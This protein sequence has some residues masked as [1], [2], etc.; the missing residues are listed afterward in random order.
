M[1]ISFQMVIARGALLLLLTMC[2]HNSAPSQDA[3]HG[4][5]GVVLKETPVNRS[6]RGMPV[7]FLPGTTQAGNDVGSDNR[8]QPTNSVTPPLFPD[9]SGFTRFPGLEGGTVR[10]ITRDSSGW[11]Y[12]GTDGE[13]YVSSDNGTHWKMNLFPSQVHNFVEPVTILGPTTI[14]AESDFYN[15]ISRDRGTTWEYISGN[16]Q[17]FAVD[18]NGVVY[19]GSDYGGV[20]RS[21]DTAKTW[22]PFGL[23]GKKV[24][25]V[26]LC[27]AGRIA[28]PSDSGSYFST[29]SGTTWR[30]RRND[31]L[32]TSA[33]I[34]DKRGRLFVFSYRD[35]GLYRSLDFGIT[36]QRLTLPSSVDVYR[37][38]VQSD[39]EVLAVG[40]GKVLSSLDGGDTWSQLDF[41][42]ESPLT[43]GRDALGNLLVGSFMGVHKWNGGSGEWEALNT[44]LYGRR[45]ECIIFTSRGSL[46]VQSL[47][48]WYR[49]TN[50]GTDWSVVQFD[51]TIAGLSAYSPGISTRSGTIF[52]A[53]AF[54]GESGF[55]RSTDDGVSWDKISV[56]ANNYFFS[57]IVESASG[58]L[59]AVNP[60]G[61]IFK[62]TN[63]GSSWERVREGNTSASSYTGTI[64]ADLNGHCYATT[65]SIVVV[66]R[67]D[68]LW[69]E[70]P[71]RRA[72]SGWESMSIDT[73]G[74]VF[75][76]VAGNGVF[77]SADSGATW[78]TMN[79]GY[80]DTYVMST[81]A[82]DSG[83]IVAGTG[84]GVFRLADS[85]N[86][87]RPFSNGLPRTYMTAMTFSPE[88][89]LYV[90]TQSFGMYRSNTPLSKRVPRIEPPPAFLPGDFALH[91]NYPNP[92]NGGTLI[93]YFLPAFARVEIKLYDVLGQEIATLVKGDFSPGEYDVRWVPGQAATGVY[94]CQMK[95]FSPFGAHNRVI[96]LLYLR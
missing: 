89:N 20:S 8:H 59:V 39:G 92:F 62:S 36:W 74:E 84:S 18:T 90:G 6:Y 55:L 81:A 75:L 37:I 54:E 4:T 25:R 86:V 69:K 61:Y 51:S 44:G 9:S 63:N 95:T 91:Q 93:R 78:K 26:W 58:A 82:D 2:I 13:V 14:V 71:L 30:F 60:R 76:G 49:S 56:M 27:G 45:I 21:F 38:N 70:T 64:A 52:L 24:W 12:L 1:A 41:P 48:N 31:T 7:L 47:W 72:Y 65:D 66:L 67:N 22:E 11:L 83:N 15:F 73:R 50:G 33:L 87:W 32:Y 40:S 35:N 17:G 29:N 5:S 23:Q 19:A 77:H 46:L 68:L 57:G 34:G 16:Y 42:I 85:V 94:F 80:L 96:K 10:S 53:A 88:G 28:C 3:M 79:G 43:A